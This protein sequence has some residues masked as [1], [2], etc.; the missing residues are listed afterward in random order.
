MQPPLTGMRVLAVEQYG[1]GPFATQHLADLGAEVIK[2]E[3]RNKGGDY[4]R[5]IGPHFAESAEA[6]ANSLFFQS[7][8]R[9][10][11]CLSLDF[12]RSDGREIFLRLV[13]SAAAVANNLRGDVP[14]RIGIN[15]DSLKDTNPSIVCAHCSAYG[16]KGPRKSWP[17]FD[18]LMQ[19]EVGYF[20]LSGEAGTAPARMG[21]PVIDFMAGTNMALGLVSSVLAARES[22]IGRD[23]DVNL[24]GTAAFNLSYIGNW[25]LNSEFAPDRRP[26]S[27]HAS[28]VPCQLFSTADGWIYIMCNKE[29]F[30]PELCDAVGH[31]E[32]ASD[33]KFATFSARWIE[34]ERLSEFFDKVLSGR[35][36]AEWMRRF[37]GR[38]PAAPV[39]EPRPALT[40][41][42]MKD[43][44]IV[45]QVAYPDG[46][47]ISILA[48]PIDTGSDRTD[49]PC[50]SIGADNDAL[51]ED[52][53]Y[54]RDEIENF[55]QKSII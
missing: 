30:W 7:V 24:F 6:N 49:R 26:R 48:S 15:Y 23:V 13:R 51:L 41:P 25:A 47:E 46:T 22:G 36:T 16:R 10:K 42:E 5:S 17:G 3:D 44:G 14:E 40:A 35:T 21:L 38:V 29:K 11:R 1:A 50:P 54:S 4:A 55:R 2:I 19:A 9:N 53:G 18:Y 37:A 28:V 12:T 32:M 39:N 43:A 8:N 20:Y 27:G 31:P 45:Q 33:P 52:I 34:R